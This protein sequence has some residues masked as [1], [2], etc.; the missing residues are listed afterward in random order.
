M[1]STMRV[2]KR[3]KQLG[4]ISLLVILAQVS[5]A[6]DIPIKSFTAKLRPVDSHKVIELDAES[7]ISLADKV[8]EALDNGI[9]LK[10]DYQVTLL[11]KRFLM[12]DAA[13]Y[14]WS[15]SR[16]L[17]YFPLSSKYVVSGN[18]D[19][20][21]RA[22]SNLPDALDDLNSLNPAILEVPNGLEDFSDEYYLQL[23]IQLDIES[24]PLPLRPLA[25]LSSSWRLHSE[26]VETLINR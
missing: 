22:F 19:N 6:A 20:S 17:S 23:Q 11:K 13:A 18:R 14:K 12:W 10:F 4:L 5:I 2:W 26:P 1:V 25:Y 16:R 9:P 24:L 15:F 7:R 21:A 3:F 8:V